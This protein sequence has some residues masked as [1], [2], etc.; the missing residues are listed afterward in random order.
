[1]SYSI[2]KKF[3][4]ADFKELISLTINYKKQKKKRVHV[5][6]NNPVKIHNFSQKRQQRMTLDRE[7][8]IKVKCIR[9]RTF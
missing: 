8:V 6:G 2:N 9:D 1:M 5:L 3:V 7:I 4:I